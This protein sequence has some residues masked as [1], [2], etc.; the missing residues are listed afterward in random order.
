[1]KSLKFWTSEDFEVSTHQFRLSER[2][3]KTYHESGSDKSGICTYTY[4]ELGFRGDSPT[5][6]GF[7]IMSIGCSNTEGLGVNDDQTWPSQ[8]SKQI[9]NGVD[10]NFGHGGRS[11]DYISR[12]LLTYYD[13]IL[14]DLVL[15]MYTEYHRR[16]YY[17]RAGGIEPFHIKQWGYFAE[18]EEGKKNHQSLINLSNRESDFQNWYKNHLLIKYFLETKKCNWMWNGWFITE[19]YQEK[20]KFDGNYYPFIDYGTDSIHPG[21]ETNKTYSIKLYNHI[22]E[23]FPEYLPL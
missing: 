23:K 3:N 15:I 6:Q 19:K 17:T 11:N 18:T 7:K 12:C 8:F 1:M 16:E 2:K 21:P 4:N 10:L 22:K 20:N 14:P 13:M 9:T 5:K